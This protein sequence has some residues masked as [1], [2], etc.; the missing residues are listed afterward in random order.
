MVSRRA[1]LQAA[2]ASAVTAAF[3]ESLVAAAAVPAAVAPILDAWL[4]ELHTRCADLR[5][6]TLPARVWQD[7]VDRLLERVPL[8]D[9]LALID[10]DR[11]VR[12]VSLP[13]D[14]AVTR[15]PVF[16]PLEGLSGPT[17][18]IRRVFLLRKDRAIVPHGHRNMASGHLVIR[19][20]L[21]V[22]HYD[23]LH[24]E[25]RHL[26]LRPTIDTEARPGAATTVSD[27][28]DNVHWLVATSELAAT[29]DVIV[30]GLDPARPTEF[31]D[32]VDPR[33]AEPLGDGS[34]RAPR[35]GTDEVFVRYG[36][37]GA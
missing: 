15:D 9:L 32:F 37:S 20:S 2:G 17:P 31:M 16:P 36:K 19:G 35:L 25:P 6:H 18:H 8:E 21:R 5:A 22:R 24:D 1:F 23:R 33:R 27:D 13:D 28:R 10:F 11:I 14:R 29:F 12:T 26:I 3:L 30:T 34:L 7:E 4:R